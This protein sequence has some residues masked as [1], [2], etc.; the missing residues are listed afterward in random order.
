MAT[1]FFY[2]LNTAAINSSILLPPPKNPPIQHSNRC[3]FLK[4]LALE[5]VK[6]HIKERN[7]QPS[8]TRKLADKLLLHSFP[9]QD[10]QTSDANETSKIIIKSS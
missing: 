2:I 9:N 1:V 10:L 3:Q 8:I 7:I 4:D 6:E 5:L